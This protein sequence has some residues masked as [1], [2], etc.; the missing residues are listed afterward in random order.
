MREEFFK[1]LL[2]LTRLRFQLIWAQMRTS[3]GRIILFF[4]L[5]LLAI[6]VTLLMTFGGL[7]AAIVA[8]DF[9][10]GGSL[11]RWMLSALFV[12]GIGLSLMFGLGTQEAFSEES[13]RRY[14]L[15]T[16]ELF[17]IRQIIGLLDPIWAFV[18]AGALG[19]A[20]GFWWFSKGSIIVGAVG[21]TLF[22]SASYLATM[23]LVSLIGR[24][25]RSRSA[26]ATFGISAL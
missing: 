21:V 24:I 25:M 8:S 10:P 16:K 2:T 1:H 19:L 22:T 3:N 6:S 17:I 23:C 18:A 14:P 13:L 26:S 12:N 7:G 9:D 15:K 20:V 5:Y 11:T 4:A